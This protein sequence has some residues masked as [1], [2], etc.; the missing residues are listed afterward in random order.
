[1]DNYEVFATDTFRKVYSAIDGSEKQWVDKIKGNLKEN[2]TG[3]IIQFQWFREKRFHSKRLFYLIDEV[4][5]R[6]LFVGFATKKEQQ[7]IIDFVV[8][9][10]KELF[11]LLKNLKTY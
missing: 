3:K 5:K 7:K 6:I 10:H 1:M 2:P 8:K 9:N 11:E 4:N